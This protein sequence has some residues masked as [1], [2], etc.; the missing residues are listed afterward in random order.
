M[1]KR[2]TSAL[3]LMLAAAPAHAQSTRTTNDF[4]WL[5]G[6]WEGHLGSDATARAEIAFSAP[7]ARS[8][9]GTMRLVKNDTVLVVELISLVDTPAGVEM[10][11][12]H[13]SPQLEAY[14]PTYKQAMRLTSFD[15]TQD[16]F[17]NTVPYDKALMST[18]P[19]TTKFIKQGADGF[20]GRSNIIGSDGKPAVIETIYKRLK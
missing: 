4:R 14:E 20:V 13:F 12:R 1:M 8:I 9:V 3:L 11:F 18:Q 5:A 7:N 6:K 15:A 10:R 2:L 17:E 19:R 16:V